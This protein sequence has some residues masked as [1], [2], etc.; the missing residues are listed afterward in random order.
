MLRR[1]RL[2]LPTRCLR[3]YSSGSKR[4][5]HRVEGDDINTLAVPDIE[6][7]ESTLERAGHAEDQDVLSTYG[8]E[9][10]AE[11]DLKP[12]DV[13][14]PFASAFTKLDDDVRTHRRRKYGNRPLPLSPVIDP[15]FVAARNRWK[16]K[17]ATPPKADELTDF[18]KKL[19]DNAYGTPRLPLAVVHGSTQIE[20]YTDKR[21]QHKP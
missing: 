8:D 19:R 4:P 7:E 21:Q 14:P 12:E 18:Q 10:P 13:H 17:K 16:M 6:V 15:V 11:S 1:P 2:G 9:E 20:M 3:D 5:G